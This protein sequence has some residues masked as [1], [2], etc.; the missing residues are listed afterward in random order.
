MQDNAKGP[1]GGAFNNV[2]PAEIEKL[3]AMASRWWEP[4]G[5][6][7]SATPNQP[8]TCSIY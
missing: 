3:N 1:G 6:L 2:D 4:E 7:S 8:T 5:R